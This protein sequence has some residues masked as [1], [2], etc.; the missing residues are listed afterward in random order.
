MT[1][2]RLRGCSAR[3]NLAALSQLLRRTKLEAAP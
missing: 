3:R 2:Q 1:A